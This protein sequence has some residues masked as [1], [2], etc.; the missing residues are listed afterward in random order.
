MPSCSYCTCITIPIGGS[1]K[2]H[3]CQVNARNHLTITCI[4]W[5]IQI[6]P[7][8][9]LSLGGSLD[10]LVHLRVDVA[11]SAHLWHL[12][13]IMECKEFCKLLLVV[14]ST[15]Y[16]GT[17]WI[18]LCVHVTIQKWHCCYNP[19]SCVCILVC[20]FCSFIVLHFI[21]LEEET[22]NL[23]SP[24]STPLV[25]LLA[26]HRC[27]E[28]VPLSSSFPLQVLRHPFPT[29]LIRGLRCSGGSL[30]LLQ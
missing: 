28:N 20:M 25:V 6:V 3:L 13:A 7:V 1:S 11:S 12:N 26:D 16:P 19:I 15:S 10:Q 14:S 24:A 30:P 2:G 22:V 29:E 8:H 23:Y 17:L 27:Y 9:I 18:E 5:V 4:A 21:V